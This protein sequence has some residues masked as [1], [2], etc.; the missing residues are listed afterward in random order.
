MI[1]V[2]LPMSYNVGGYTILIEKQG[3]AAVKKVVN[4][5]ELMRTPEWIV[6]IKKRKGLALNGSVIHQEYNRT[7]P[8]AAVELFNLCTGEYERT[9][10]D[11]EGNFEFFLECNC[12]YEVLAKKER[13]LDDKKK[14]STVGLD[15]QTAKDINSILYLNIN[16]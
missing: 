10:T 2:Y 14:Y 9:V 4:A 3:Y 6:P 16:L 11:D 1:S 8:N 15:C 7:I 5:Y 13:F 12:D